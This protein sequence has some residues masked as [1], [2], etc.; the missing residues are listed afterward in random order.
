MVKIS[1]KEISKKGKNYRYEEIALVFC[2]KLFDFQWEI[3]AEIFK[4]GSLV[5]R[6]MN[7]Q[8]KTSTNPLN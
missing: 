4:K 6:P 3:N 7:N 5:I 2:W 1:N 8:L